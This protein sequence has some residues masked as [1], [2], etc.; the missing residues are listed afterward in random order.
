MD[1]SIA[2]NRS[3]GQSAEPKETPRDRLLKSRGQS[4]SSKPPVS[5]V[6]IKRDRIVSV[7]DQKLK[8]PIV[9]LNMSGST[10]STIKQPHYAL[11]LPKR[12][13]TTP[14]QR[15]RNIVARG[16]SVLDEPSL[17]KLEHL[18]GPEM[19][20]RLCDEYQA[21]YETRDESSIFDF[22]SYFQERR[23]E[24]DEEFISA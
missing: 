22:S 16:K 12:I 13:L 10:S 2:S 20:I 23:A 5:G 8:I 11:P 21:N 9:G 17:V 3:R 4:P 18:G 6:I 19:H 14:A 24:R 1:H 7:P 15:L